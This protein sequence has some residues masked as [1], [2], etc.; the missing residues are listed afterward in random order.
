MQTIKDQS[1][2]KEQKV[3]YLL[4]RQL[5]WAFGK[6]KLDTL[7]QQE[8]ERLQTEIDKNR[9]ELLSFEDAEIDNFYRIELYLDEVKK[10]FRTTYPV[11]IKLNSIKYSA[12]LRYWSKMDYWDRD[13]A[14]ILSFG[15]D[16]EKLKET[17]EHQYGDDRSSLLKAI[18]NLNKLVKTHY[19]LAERAHPSKY[20]EFFKEKEIIFPEKLAEYVEKY[21]PDRFEK[22]ASKPLVKPVYT[23]PYIELM[24]QAIQ[25]HRIT[26]SNQ[27]KKEFLTE[28]FL[29]KS[30][31]QTQISKNKAELMA[32]FIRLPESG[33]GGNKANKK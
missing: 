19:H 17:Q 14:V 33:I 13:Q 30:T 9:K 7:T 10:P 15:R 8:R 26:E 21:H 23:T 28:W 12:N 20:I 22:K 29:S 6:L 16:P 27:S 5:Y 18:K 24:F 4:Q 11:E 3:E 1:L 2:T 31:P 32:T 25:E